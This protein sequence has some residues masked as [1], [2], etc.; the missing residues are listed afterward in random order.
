LPAGKS[1]TLTRTTTCDAAHGWLWS[2]ST[3][4]PIDSNSTQSEYPITSL[5]Y[6]GNVSHTWTNVQRFTSGNFDDDG[7]VR[8]ISLSSASGNPYSAAPGSDTVGVTVVTSEAGISKQLVVLRQA[9][10]GSSTA[11]MLCVDGGS[12]SPYSPQQGTPGIQ[13]GM[14]NGCS[15]SYAINQNLGAV[16]P[17][18]N[19]TLLPAQCV[20]NKTSNAGGNPLVSTPLNNRFGCSS[21]GTPAY[22]NNWPNFSVPGDK[23]AV[24]LLLT[25]YNAYSNGGKTNGRQNYPV[26]GFGDFYVTG[27]SGDKCAG[28]D[29]APPQVAGDNQN[30]GDIWGY[31]IKYDSGG[32]I[33]SGAKCVPN[34]LGECVAA[35]VR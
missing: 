29:P 13:N 16:D 35:L 9:H 11:F 31:F 7:P 17:C 26:V 18:A 14:Q 1:I 28:D 33:P 21:G 34:A 23:R 10:N 30:A 27:F 22:P 12:G 15:F 24:T 20:P 19:Q 4:L 32:G 8:M 2:G 25:T 6:V 3:T 5:A